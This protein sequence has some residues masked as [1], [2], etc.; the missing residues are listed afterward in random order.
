MPSEYGGAV[1]QE[2]RI[3]ARP[4]TV[5]EFFIDPE[6]MTRWKGIERQSRPKTGRLVPG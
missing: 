5:F 3:A 6:K 1:E 2:V 4:E